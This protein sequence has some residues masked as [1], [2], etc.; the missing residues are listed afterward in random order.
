MPEF[1]ALR[2]RPDRVD[3]RIRGNEEL[4]VRRRLDQLETAQATGS[5]LVSP[6]MR[7][8]GGFIDPAAR[9]SPPGRGTG[10]G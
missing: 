4:G 7:Y 8:K 9:L 3:E 5:P 1:E 2:P 6:G 10:G